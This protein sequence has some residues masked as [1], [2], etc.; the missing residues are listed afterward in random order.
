MYPGR[1]LEKSIGEKETREVTYILWVSNL[2]SVPI[3][4][5]SEHCSLCWPF[6]LPQKT[7]GKN[8]QAFPFPSLAYKT[9]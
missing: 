4:G 5:N 7:Q 9:T 2:Q 6:F 1:S 3:S 8:R